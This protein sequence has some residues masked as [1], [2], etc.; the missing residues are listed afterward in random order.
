[1]E[2][3]GSREP[4]PSALHRGRDDLNNETSMRAAPRFDGRVHL[5]PGAA[6]ERPNG[7]KTDV[8]RKRH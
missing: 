8:G 3:A 4:R 5:L 1:M 7:A 2:T 6:P